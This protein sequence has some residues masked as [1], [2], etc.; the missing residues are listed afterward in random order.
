MVK[1]ARAVLVMVTFLSWMANVRT[2]SFIA[3][4]AL[5]VFP[6]CIQDS[7]Y[8]GVPIAGHAHWAEVGGGIMCVT[9][10]ELSGL[11]KIVPVIVF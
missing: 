6:S 10:G 7:G 2:S 8:G 4:M 1:L 9:L 5:L 11:H 3:R